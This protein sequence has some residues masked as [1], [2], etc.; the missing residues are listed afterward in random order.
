MKLARRVTGRSTVI[1]FT[2]AYHGMSAG[3]AGV[4]ASPGMRTGVPVESQ[5]VVRMPFS[6][7]ETNGQEVLKTVS[8]LVDD[9]K[10]GIELPAAVII[11]PIQGEGGV[12]VA[13]DGF[14]TAL[15]EFATQRSIIVI[16]DEIQ[17]GVGHS[18][19]M[20]AS[21]YADVV[22][23]ILVMS[24]ALGGSLPLAVIAYAERLDTWPPG[25]HTGTFRGT[26][27][28]MAAGAATLRVIEE[29]QLVS[30][31]AATGSQFKDRLSRLVERGLAADV[32]GRGLMLGINAG[33]GERAGRVRDSAFTAGLMLE[34]GGRNGE[35][36]RRL[37]PLNTTD[38]DFDLAGSILEQSF[39]DCG[40]C[41]EPSWPTGSEC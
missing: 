34:T 3:A 9:P 18:G 21:E 1:A 30:R 4:S 36:V 41:P 40:Q 38:A 2:G 29:D 13:P 37:P 27:L 5:P 15:Y 14:Y 31:A 8:D 10:S 23:D 7:N 25:A 32:R 39:S 19:N 33:T 11:E 22:P 35:I 26:T 28:A 16:A 17:C 24:K 6:C 12:N 20:W